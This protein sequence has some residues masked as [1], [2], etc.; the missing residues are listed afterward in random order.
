MFINQNLI[1]KKSININAHSLVIWDIL[2]NPSKIKMYLFGKNVFTDWKVGRNILFEGE[3]DGEKYTDK[4]TILE[5]NPE[6]KL[7]YTYLSGLS[8]LENEK[9][10][11]SIITFEINNNNLT[12]TQKGFKSKN[13]KNV[14]KLKW[15][16]VLKNIKKIAE[17]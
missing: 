7:K 17:N 6:K 11:Y 4:G 1:I 10:N 15:E 9:N 14:L 3:Y 12:L 16:H 13:E 5:I 8:G 2:V